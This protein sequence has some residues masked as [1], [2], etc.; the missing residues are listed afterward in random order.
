MCRTEFE[1]ARSLN[2]AES[3]QKLLEMEIYLDNLVVSLP[4]SPP[5]DALCDTHTM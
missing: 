3:Q 2:E 4:L 1:A 5:P